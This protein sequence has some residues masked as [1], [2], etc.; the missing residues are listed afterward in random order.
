[1]K[2]IKENNRVLAIAHSEKDW[3]KGLDFLTPAD[4]YVQVGTWWYDKGTTLDAHRH[5]DYERVSTRTHETVY[6]K[7]GKLRVLLYDEDDNYLTDFVLNHGDLVVLA[8][9][10]H[11]YQ[12]LEDDTQV[13]E[14]KNGP[15][16]DVDRGKTRF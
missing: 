14:S 6:V 8:Y 5:N 2:V 1:M 4:L 12:V 16:T 7:Q 10:G 15:F 13:I 9:G 3:Q 11:G